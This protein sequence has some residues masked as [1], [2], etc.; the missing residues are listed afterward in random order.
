MSKLSSGKPF[1]R[2]K[3][4]MPAWVVFLLSV[5]VHEGFAQ[6]YNSKVRLYNK[7]NTLVCLAMIPIM[8]FD[9]MR[10]YYPGFVIASTFFVT[11]AG[12]FWLMHKG[13]FF[14]VAW[15]SI[16]IVT[17]GIIFLILFYG[18]EIGGELTFI[19][20]G[21]SC[22]VIFDSWKSRLILLVYVYCAYIISELLLYYVAPFTPGARIFPIYLV[23]FGTNFL[24]A[25]TMMVY[26]TQ[27]GERS[28][29]EV[30]DLME[31]LENRND[32]LEKA[33]YDLAQF[34]YAASHHFKSPLK[35]IS[36]LLGL[37]EKKLPKETLEKHGNYLEL[38]LTDSKHLY[39]LVEDIL[40][41]STLDASTFERYSQVDISK[42]LQR[43]TNNLSDELNARHVKLVVKEPPAIYASETHIELMLQIL[44]QNGFHYNTSEIPSIDISGTEAEDGSVTLSISDNGIGIPVEYQN[45]VFD[46]FE[47]LHSHSEYQGS[48]IGLTVCR[49]IMEGYGG[50]ILLDSSRGNGSTFRL[51]FP[52]HHE[53][54]E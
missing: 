1:G 2:L 14:L 35:N 19:G 50:H 13:K 10:G 43:V 34:A 8:I 23:I 46:M 6:N 47:R 5:G 28:E 11:T 53:G 29:Q 33:N 39:N 38:I 16:C 3:F 27:Q 12:S 42:V 48:G 37:L 25:V 41:Y 20:I 7:M 26:F 15:G 9:L 51:V 4:K 52:P 54:V 17:V 40:T 49:R 18:R 45:Q 44:I 36:N 21:L 31:D 32:E 24:M 22:I 30:D